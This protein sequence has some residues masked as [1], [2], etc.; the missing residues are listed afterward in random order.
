MNKKLTIEISCNEYQE[1]EKL[2][3]SSNMSMDKY[4][5]KIIKKYI[6]AVKEDRSS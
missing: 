4:I 3:E 6:D 5:S 2:A 1:I